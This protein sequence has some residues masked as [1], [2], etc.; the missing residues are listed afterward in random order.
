MRHARID[1]MGYRYGAASACLLALTLFACTFL[2]RLWSLTRRVL[3]STNLVTPTKQV[4][5]TWCYINTPAYYASMH[6]YNRDQYSIKCSYT[7]IWFDRAKGELSEACFFGAPRYTLAVAM[8][9]NTGKCVYGVLDKLTT[10]SRSCSF[11]SETT[12]AKW[13]S[14]TYVEPDT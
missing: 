7:S 13:P 11:P 4:A 12:K 6:E 3:R 14:C 10:A 8:P 9:S 2:L 1:Q 5:G